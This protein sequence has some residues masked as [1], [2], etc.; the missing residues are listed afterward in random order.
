MQTKYQRE[1]NIQEKSPNAIAIL[2]GDF[3]P[4]TTKI[5]S[6]IKWKPSN[7][8]QQDEHGLIVGTNARLHAGLSLAARF[9]DAKIVTTS[10]ARCPTTP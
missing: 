2:D 10:K 3:F 9:S 6:Q 4:H 8:L 5:R 1:L 7:Y